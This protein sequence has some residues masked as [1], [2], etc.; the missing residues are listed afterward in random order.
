MDR[1]VQARPALSPR[2]SNAYVQQGQRVLLAGFTNQAV[3]NMLKRLDK[4][5]FPRHIY[6]WDMNEASTKVSDHAY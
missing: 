4:D 5:G 3:D 2:S 6:A 1:Q